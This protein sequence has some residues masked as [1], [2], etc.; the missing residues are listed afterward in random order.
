MG[1]QGTQG[2]QGETGTCPASCD[3]V[4]GPPGQQGLPGPAGARGL[5]GVL[6]AVGPKGFKGDKGDMGKAGNHGLNGLKGDRGEQGLC[7]C[8]DGEDGTDG[9]PGERGPKGD[10]GDIGVQGIQ[11]PMGL[12][13]NQGV[14]GLMGPRGP[15]SPAIQSA[16]SACLNQS[17]P[18]EN[19]PVIFPHI[20]YNKQGHFNTLKGIYTAPVNGTYIFTFNLAVSNKV[21]KVG[22]F[23]NFY[24]IIKTTEGNS[25]A[26][27]SQTVVLH[28]NMFD[29]VWLQVKNSVTNG[30]FTD[31]E[32]TSTFSGYLLH[33]D[34]CELPVG[35][36]FLP[37][38]HHQ[39]GDFSWEGP[40]P[41]ATTQPPL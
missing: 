37:Q 19:M 34:S 3:S 15:C 29:E 41:A 8:T 35:R 30:M 27:T 32:S 4:Q 40:P 1:P 2:L 39:K 5:P 14:I 21:L 16:F 12:K 23:H 24:P 11:G 31:N 6:G 13:G 26:T 28:L 20:L 36:H 25:Q 22:L 7:N 10:K 9:R 18:T 17:F 38:R 33:P